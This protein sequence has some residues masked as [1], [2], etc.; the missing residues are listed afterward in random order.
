MCGA[1]GEALVNGFL[2]KQ[3]QARIP[4]PAMITVV[5]RSGGKLKVQ[6]WSSFLH[7]VQLLR[8]VSSVH[9]VV[10]LIA[11]VIDRAGEGLGG[12]F[13]EELFLGCGDP[14]LILILDTLWHAK[15]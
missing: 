14:E 13:W 9:I 5:M 15:V 4:S 11:E 8:E 10:S 1:P 7:V 6:C 12:V 3:Q 2:Q